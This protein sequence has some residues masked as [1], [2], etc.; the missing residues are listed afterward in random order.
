MYVAMASYNIMCMH[1]AL[2]YAI[3]FLLGGFHFYG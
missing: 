2:S 3:Y 1:I